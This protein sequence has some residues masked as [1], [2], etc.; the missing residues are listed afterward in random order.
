MNLKGKT[1]LAMA[2]CAGIS[3][4][5]ALAQNQSNHTETARREIV[6]SVDASLGS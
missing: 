4:M 1:V 6:A 2:A 3:F 5:P